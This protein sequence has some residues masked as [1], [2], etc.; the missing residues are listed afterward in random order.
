[1]IWY[2]VLYYILLSYYMYYT[3]YSILCYDIIWCIPCYTT[4]YYNI[5]WNGIIWHHVMLYDIDLAKYIMFYWYSIH[6]VSGPRIKILIWKCWG[7]LVGSNS[8]GG[9]NSAPTIHSVF[10]LLRRSNGACIC[11]TVVD[12]GLLPRIP[13]QI[14]KGSTPQTPQNSE[15]GPL[16]L[17]QELL[18]V[19]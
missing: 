19:G 15:S 11:A 10:P 9:H 4:I 18:C 7:S 12:G 5:L 6:L 14:I 16:E 8:L 1:M 17:V 13:P 3:L 2:D